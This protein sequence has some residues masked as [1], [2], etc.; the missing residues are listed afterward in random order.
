MLSYMYL[1]SGGV[2]CATPTSTQT[3]RFRD[4]RK[5]R[6][7]TTDPTFEFRKN[8]W[9]HSRGGPLSCILSLF[10][11]VVCGDYAMDLWNPP[12]Y[13]LST[14]TLRR[15]CEYTRVLIIYSFMKLNWGA[16]KNTIKRNT[17]L[18]FCC[19]N[20]CLIA[21]K[22]CIFAGIFAYIC[23]Y[24][25]KIALTQRILYR[26][27]VFRHYRLKVLPVKALSSVAILQQ[28]LKNTPT[29]T[30]FFL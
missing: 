15:L 8:V 2:Q 24:L 17:N 12:Q 21:F 16:H 14:A 18:G 7:E 23:W 22:L 10:A 5:L 13:S 3:G 11:Q 26:L 6:S 28:K 30:Q 4:R 25:C 19:T 29:F 9:G 1:I 20:L 27:K